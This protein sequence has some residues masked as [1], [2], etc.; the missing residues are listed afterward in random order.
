VTEPGLADLRSRLSVRDR[1]TAP[2][3]AAIGKALGDRYLAALAKRPKRGFGLSM[4]PWL[5]GPLA[6]L[7]TATS[8]PNAPVP[9][10]VDRARATQAGLASPH[11]RRR[12]AETWALTALNAWLETWA[13][14]LA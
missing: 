5:A 4:G 9:S 3:K 8:E 6:P 2:G 12:W 7:V 13:G 1:N 11:P 10:L 14:N